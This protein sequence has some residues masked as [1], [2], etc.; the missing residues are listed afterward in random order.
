MEVPVT[1]R[2]AVQPQEARVR[3]KG[4][5]LGEMVAMAESGFEHMASPQQAPRSTL[6][7]PDSN[8]P[9][10]QSHELAKLAAC[11]SY[12]SF[13]PDERP[14]DAEAAQ[15]LTDRRRPCITF[16]LKDHLAAHDREKRFHGVK[17]LRRQRHVVLVEHHEIRELPGFE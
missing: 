7:V 6:P 5:I 12:L 10:F 14:A 3:V 16:F 8:Q 17:L 15:A 4:D 11:T 9:A 1:V 2:P 13:I